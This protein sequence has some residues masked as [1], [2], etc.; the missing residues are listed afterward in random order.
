MRQKK[1]GGGEGG[2]KGKNRIKDD[3]RKI[4]NTPRSSASV[5]GVEVMVM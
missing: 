5:G 3:A 4:N 2:M 1:G